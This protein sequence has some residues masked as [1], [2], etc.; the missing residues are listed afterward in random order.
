MALALAFLALLSW[1]LAER[2]AVVRL[3]H[4]ML[5]ARE[6]LLDR[7]SNDGLRWTFH[8]TTI[9]E[10]NHTITILREMFVSVD[11][12]QRDFINQ[13]NKMNTILQSLPGALLSLS[14]DLQ[15]ISAN[16]TAEE[17]FAKQ[18]SPLIGAN[19][20]DLLHL[21]ERDRELLRDAF[22]Y[23]Q[24]IRSQEIS[25][26]TGAGQRYFSLNLGFYSDEDDELG[27]IL[28]LQDISEY[29][30]LQ[31][32]VAMR[33]KFV[34]M[35][36]FAAGVAHELNTPL[37]NV[38][39]YAQLLG[40]LRD[41]PEKLTEYTRIIADETRRCS[42]IVKD[43][44]NYA[45]DDHCSGETCNVNQLVTELIETFIE[46]RMKRYNIDVQLMLS[47][48]SIIVESDRGQLEIVLTNLLINSIHAL[49]GVEQ[50]TITIATSSEG[51]H[52]IIS[53][54]DNGPGVPAELRHRIFD[55]FFTTKPV[56]QGS[57]LGLSI[58]HAM[59]AKRGGYILYDND[60]VAGA[61]FLIKIPAVDLSRAVL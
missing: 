31:D 43:L 3:L 53:V 32:S 22:L 11:E 36:Q 14:D 34:A 55:P 30:L 54:T 12:C 44:L 35:G 48:T 24:P 4:G 51:A 8:G 18:N 13:R 59:L 6:G 37:G 7:V 49:D 28:I 20:F 38:L 15:V 9:A 1:L 26:T 46:C 56:G 39:G 45:R 19:L 60:H 25:M 17:L 23:K 33:E 16:K 21:N 29:R 41:D 58:S 42:R 47:D 27:G 50:P 61:R 2:L 57:G 40:R 5:S 10:Y 52:G